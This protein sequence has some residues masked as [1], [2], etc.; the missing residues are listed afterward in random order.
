MIDADVPAFWQ[1]LGLPGIFDAHT[2]FL[3]PNIQAAVWRQ[4][5][6]A[7]P[8]LGREWPITYRLEVD[9]RVEV[10]R[11]LGVR[12]F[13]AHPYA[14]KPGVATY[15]NGWCATFAAEVPEC[16]RS[17]TFYP[18]PGV[19][20]YVEVL[21]A[22]G[23][24]VFK[25]HTQVGEFELDDPLLLPAWK[26]LE[27]SG[28]PVTV[29]VGSG[30][31]PNE[32]TGIHYLS[33]LMEAFPRLQVIVAHMGAPEIRETL[34]LVDRYERLH[35][36]T[37]MIFTDFFGPHAVW[38]DRFKERLV[39][40]QDRILLGTDFPSIPHP[41]AHQLEALERLGLGD[42]WLRAVCWENGLRVFGEAPSSGLGS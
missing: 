15:L 7:G 8:K 18:E 4:F 31:V 16:L 2:H 30:P 35:V 23:V 1:R 32:F 40:Q 41:Y 20:E 33:R 34:Q 36:D 29:H 13:T 9:E 22:G 27:E 12:H 24:E 10:L 5:D 28:T 21:V 26:V 14:H 17:A 11:G 38:S 6:A 3:P 39:R 37:T 25:V 42:D 19:G